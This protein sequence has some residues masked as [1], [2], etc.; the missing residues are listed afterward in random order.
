MYQ[1]KQNILFQEVI[2]KGQPRKQKLKNN[3]K[4]IL[5]F[6]AYPSDYLIHL[7]MAIILSN[8]GHKVTVLIKINSDD[9]MNK[10][11]KTK[12]KYEEYFGEIKPELLKYG[13]RIFF[14]NDLLY[15]ETI[16]S[17]SVINKIE[18]QSIEDSQRILKNPEFKISNRIHKN[19][20]N[21][22]LKENTKF[23]KNFMNFTKEKKFNN[24]IIHSGSW[25][26]YGIAFKILK[27]LKKNIIC[28]GYRNDK[29]TIVISYNKQFNELDLNNAWKRK[30]KKLSNTEQRISN[31]LTHSFTKKEY[32][33]KRVYLNFH[34][35]DPLN[36]EKLIKKLKLKKKFG[37]ILILTSLSFDTTVLTKKTNHIFES[38]FQ[39]LKETINFLEKENY[40]IIVRP[41]PAEN[42]TN[43]KMTCEKFLKKE[44]KNISNN[45]II[46]PSNTDINT[47]GLID[48]VD[49]GIVYSSDIGWEMILRKKPVIACGKGVAWGKGI[50]FEPKNL[51]EYYELLKKILN[52]EINFDKRKHFLLAQKFMYLYLNEVP[53]I[54]P[55]PLREFWSKKTFN[56]L[57]KLIKNNVHSKKY[58]KT[59]SIL[60]SEKKLYDGLLGKI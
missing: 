45:I 47:Y 51:K 58:D 5:V 16:L 24:Y 37:N 32:Y 30:N 26:E 23:A 28:F 27:K 60:S 53:K 41:H 29:N 8:R 39:W 44:I 21:Y 54:F 10:E 56:D 31:F 49:F 7:S 34:T 25:A 40:N 12:T 36:K 46:L 17:S 33:K 35:E 11:R 20:F 43:C 6:S 3:F 59:F 18:R 14:T 55:F 48:I 1:N 57:Q 2:R 4:D 19:I 50:Q 9:E 13:I 42:L 22:R 15:K 52:K 38:Q